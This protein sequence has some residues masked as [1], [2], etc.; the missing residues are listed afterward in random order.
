MQSQ[1]VFQE[2]KEM[3]RLSVQNELLRSC[4]ADIFTHIF[5]GK[6]DLAVLDIGSNDGSKTFERFSAAAVSRVIGLEYNAGLAKQAQA[7]YGSD[8]FAFYSLDA[9]SPGFSDQLKDVMAE[10]G[11]DGFDVIYLSFVLMHLK[12]AGRL[13]TALK[14]FLK[15]DGHL[16]IVEAD[17]GASY[18]T[19]DE[20]GLLGEFLRILKEDQYSGNREIGAC[21]ENRL[22][23]CGYADITVWSRGIAAGPGE[24]ARKE[25]I[26]TTFFS[27]LPEDVA[28]LLEAEPDNARYH[29]WAAWIRSNYPRLEKLIVQEE[30]KISMGMKILSCMKGG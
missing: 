20:D 6:R 24:K 28:L 18:L 22:T 3:Q 19:P 10:N 8:R 16:V 15:S 1:L 14:P 26:Y 29:S 5:Q 30:T 27:Y 11:V 25:A 7:Q 4:E 2:K 21:L 17:D 9:E 13:L 12:D 23:D